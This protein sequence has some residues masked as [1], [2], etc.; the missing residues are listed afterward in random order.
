MM[1]RLPQYVK[2]TSRPKVKG[3]HLWIRITFYDC[4]ELECITDLDLLNIKSWKGFNVKLSTGTTS[5]L[6]ELGIPRCVIKDVVALG[7]IGRDN[8][9]Y[10]NIEV[11][12]S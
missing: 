8:I 10:S 9:I 6:L 5:P 3:D 11:G 1:L 12:N 7:V 2:S 4:A